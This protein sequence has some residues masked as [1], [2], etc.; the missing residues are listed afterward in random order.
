MALGLAGY[1]RNLPQT[2]S[3]EVAA[4]GERPQLE[5]LLKYVYRGPVDARVENVEVQWGPFSGEFSSFRIR[6]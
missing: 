1:A 6:Y 3:V 2:R 4:E 5:E